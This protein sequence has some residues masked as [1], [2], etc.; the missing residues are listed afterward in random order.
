MEPCEARESR[1]LLLLVSYF[2][3]YSRRFTPW[4]VKMPPTPIPVRASAFTQPSLLHDSIRLPDGWTG[5]YIRHDL[6]LEVCVG[7]SCVLNLL[8]FRNSLGYVVN[9]VFR[10]IVSYYEDRRFSHYVSAVTKSYAF[11]QNCTMHTSVHCLSYAFY[12]K[13]LH[14]RD[15]V[16]SMMALSTAVRLRTITNHGACICI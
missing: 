5:V 2:R 14:V 1:L 8:R 16:S 3:C 9:Y 4:R 11:R 6:S 13:H 10:N 15:T 12:R 7:S